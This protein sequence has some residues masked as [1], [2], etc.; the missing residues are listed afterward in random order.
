MVLCASYSTS[1]FSLVD[2]ANSWFCEQHTRQQTSPNS[3][4]MSGVWEGITE[5]SLIPAFCREV[6]LN[7][8]PLAQWRGF[9][10]LRQAYRSTHYT[11]QKK[12][13]QHRR[14]DLFQVKK[15]EMPL[16]KMNGLK[17]T[18]I[19]VTRPTACIPRKCHASVMSTY[20]AWQSSTSEPTHLFVHDVSS[21]TM[22]TALQLW[23]RFFFLIFLFFNILFK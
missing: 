8:R 17:P 11:N 7:P 23:H 18:I 6:A 20:V 21:L 10:P 19:L 3:S 13:F 9:S 12:L 16:V 1:W 5:L 4:H 15:T 2:I 22:A 14:E